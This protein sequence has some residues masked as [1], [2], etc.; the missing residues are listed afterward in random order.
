MRPRRVIFSSCAKSRDAERARHRNRCSRVF[1]A[2][3]LEGNRA[4]L[5]LG[6]ILYEYRRNSGRVKKKIQWAVTRGDVSGLVWP[7]IRI[8]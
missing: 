7:G 6:Y 5:G 8:Q 4:V 2:A 1:M 3:P